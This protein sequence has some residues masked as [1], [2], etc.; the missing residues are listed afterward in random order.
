MCCLVG[1]NSI[2]FTQDNFKY[3]LQSSQSDLVNIELDPTAPLH[4]MLLALDRQHSK[5]PPWVM[6]SSHTIPTSI[7][8]LPQPPSLPSLHS[9]GSGAYSSSPSLCLDLCLTCSSSLST[10]MLHSL[11]RLPSINPVWSDRHPHP[12][13]HHYLPWSCLFSQQH[14]LIFATA[15]LLSIF[16]TRLCPLPVGI[17]SSGS[18]LCPQGP[19]V[20]V[21][22]R[23]GL[24]IYWINA[25]W[26]FSLLC[27]HRKLA[28]FSG[29]QSCFIFFSSCC[30]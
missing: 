14:L 3:I 20:M 2:A 25:L 18:P 9:S 10:S 26:F 13:T 21:G 16:S 23:G 11:E 5:W 6:A 12:Q 29:T 19:E 17:L 28:M 30:I 1:A 24:K 15:W 27:I 22:L 7:P 8:P 4:R